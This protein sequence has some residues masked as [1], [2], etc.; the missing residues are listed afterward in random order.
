[1]P[2]HRAKRPTLEDTEAAVNT[3]LLGVGAAVSRQEIAAATGHSLMSVGAALVALPEAVRV[4]RGQ[5]V[6]TDAVGLTPEQLQTFVRCLDECSDLDGVLDPDDLARIC[7]EGPW[8]GAT[9]DLALAVGCTNVM[10]LLVRGD[11]RG[12]TAKAAVVQLGG[13]ATTPEVAAAV[14]FSETRANGALNACKSLYRCAP[15]TWTPHPDSY[16]TFRDVLERHTQDGVVNRQAALAEL[17]EQSLAPPM[18]RL[19]F[20]G[21]HKPPLAKLGRRGYWHALINAALAHLGRPAAANEIADYIPTTAKEIDIICKA[22]PDRFAAVSPKWG[23]RC[24]QYRWTIRTAGLDHMM[25]IQDGYIDDSGLIGEPALRARYASLPEAERFDKI[26]AAAGHARLFGRL[27]VGYTDEALT[28]AAL[29]H[30]ARPASINEL[31]CLTGIGHDTTRATLRSCRSVSSNGH[32]LYEAQP[33]DTRC[34]P[35]AVDGVVA[36]RRRLRRAA[37][38]VL[39]RQAA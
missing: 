12:G 15:R 24:Q 39:R 36:L 37:R 3:M 22:A 4:N 13:R 25:S 11:L 34:G 2:K 17:A 5:W 9:T 20:N 30:L 27:A 14:G 35:G 19:A 6:H 21:D 8:N 26:S 23:G 33:P 18:M 7:V 38:V 10:G 28:K 1:M 29:L 31:A 16:Q 32:G